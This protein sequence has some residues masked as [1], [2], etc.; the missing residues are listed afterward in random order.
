MVCFHFGRIVL[1]SSDALH[2]SSGLSCPQE[3]GQVGQ[4]ALSWAQGTA[5]IKKAN[6]KFTFPPPRRALQR[7]PR[8]S[9]VSH[10]HSLM[11]P[12]WQ[13]EVRI[14]PTSP[15]VSS[16]AAPAQ[17]EGKPKGTWVPV[18][19]RG[20]FA[21]LCRVAK[22]LGLLLGDVSLPEQRAACSHGQAGRHYVGLPAGTWPHEGMKRML[23]LPRSQVS[24]G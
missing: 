3:T 19:L 23:S 7:S 14:T 15:L 5:G 12:S 4:R 18:G 22:P 20:P 16:E 21:L 17:P 11:P 1:L 13:R 24:K 9:G 2:C 6:S 10:Q 8:T